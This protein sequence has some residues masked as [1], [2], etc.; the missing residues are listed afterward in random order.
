MGDSDT[1]EEESMTV[2]KVTHDIT[3]DPQMQK[4]PRVSSAGTLIK[5]DYTMTSLRK[6]RTRFEDRH[7]YIFGAVTFG[8][9]MAALYELAFIGGLL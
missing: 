7:P 3:S 6:D 9:L 1:R 4:H 5:E 8:I 2:Y